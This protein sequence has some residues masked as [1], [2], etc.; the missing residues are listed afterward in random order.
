MSWPNPVRLPVL[1][2][3]A[4][5]LAL[6]ALRTVLYIPWVWVLSPLWIPAILVVVFG[7]LE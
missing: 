4:L 1:V 6:L 3:A 7:A 2:M 5:T